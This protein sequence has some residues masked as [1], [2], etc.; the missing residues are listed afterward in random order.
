MAECFAP[1]DFACVRFPDHTSQ[2]STRYWAPSLELYTVVHSLKFG[3]IGS[4]ASLDTL[5][6]DGLAFHGFDLQKKGLLP[7]GRRMHARLSVSLALVLSVSLASCRP[8]GQAALDGIMYSWVGQPRDAFERAWG[9]PI[10]EIPLTTGGSLLI[11]HRAEQ[12]NEALGGDRE[13]SALQ[14][15]RVEVETDKYRRIVGWRYQ[16]ECY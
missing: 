9:P 5:L 1:F 4:L 10:R 3:Q 15:C 13:A 11:Y 16:G 7:K 2:F 12:Q 14:R 8:S 6:T